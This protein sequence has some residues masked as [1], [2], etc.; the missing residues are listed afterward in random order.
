MK[1]VMLFRIFLFSALL[2]SKHINAD[3]AIT[4]IK[5]LYTSIKPEYE[6]WLPIHG[7]IAVQTDFLRNLFLMEMQEEER[8]KKEAGKK[9]KSLILNKYSGKK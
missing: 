1:L 6:Y 3:L 8:R 2:L 7:V 4:D 5:G 9:E